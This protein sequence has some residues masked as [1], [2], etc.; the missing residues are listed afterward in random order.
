MRFLD[1]FVTWEY[2]HVWVILCTGENHPTTNITEMYF[3]YLF[4]GDNVVDTFVLNICKGHH[5]QTN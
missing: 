4:D 5:H 1:A 3:K 2:N